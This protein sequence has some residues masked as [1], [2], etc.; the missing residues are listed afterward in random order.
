MAYNKIEYYA[1]RNLKSV[2]CSGWLIDIKFKLNSEGKPEIKN[3]G[4]CK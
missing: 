3:K 1:N 2:E 4:G